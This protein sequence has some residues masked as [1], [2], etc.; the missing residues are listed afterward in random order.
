MLASAESSAYWVA[1]KRRLHSA[2][3][4]ATTVTPPMPLAKFSKPTAAAMPMLVWPA[5]ASAAKLKFDT[6]IRIRLIS[7]ERFIPS[8][9][10]R[11][12][13]TK[14]PISSA[15]KPMPTS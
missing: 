6:A 8:R 1:V 9:A 12:P 15:T 3:R 4:Y 14:T 11:M 5:A 13:P 2:D 10:Y 7:T